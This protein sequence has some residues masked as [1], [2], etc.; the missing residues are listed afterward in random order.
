MLMILLTIGTRCDAGSIRLLIRAV[1]VFLQV[2][3]R[4]PPTAQKP[5]PTATNCPNCG[6]A[7]NLEAEFCPNCG[8]KVK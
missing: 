3:R 7:L 5:I 1:V 2:V 6:A 4:K 8:K